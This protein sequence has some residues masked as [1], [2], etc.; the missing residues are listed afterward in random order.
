MEGVIQVFNFQSFY[1]L[2]LLQRTVKDDIIYSYYIWFTLKIDNE[3]FE[4]F[5]TIQD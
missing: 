5:F 3:Q 1:N 4:V 2:Q